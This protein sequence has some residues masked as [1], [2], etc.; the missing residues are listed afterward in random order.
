MK[1]TD[2]YNQIPEGTAYLKCSNDGSS[3]T[4]I[5]NG[6]WMNT[7]LTESD[8]TY[9]MK[10]G[11]DAWSGYYFS[12]ITSKDQTWVWDMEANK[13]IEQAYRFDFLIKVSKEDAPINKKYVYEV[14]SEEATK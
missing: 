11:V 1:S 12:G 3:F 5:T 6:A 7:T 8:P 14:K 9:L 13:V 10:L 2:Y 4:K